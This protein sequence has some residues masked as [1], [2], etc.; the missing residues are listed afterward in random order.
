[1]F[2][3]PVATR[4]S[5]AQQLK[6][7]IENRISQR[8]KKII[9]M[10]ALKSGSNHLKRRLDEVAPQINSISIS[11]TEGEIRL[12]DTRRLIVNTDGFVREEPTP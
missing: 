11:E 1:L 5:N 2:I 12:D 7:Y 9:S 6:L 10:L 8:C 3:D 4:N